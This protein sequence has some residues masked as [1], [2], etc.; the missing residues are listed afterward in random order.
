MLAEHLE[1][2]A[3]WPR[4]LEAARNLFHF[5]ELE[6]H[7]IGEDFKTTAGDRVFLDEVPAKLPGRDPLLGGPVQ[8]SGT[9]VKTVIAAAVSMAAANSLCFDRTAMT[10]RA[11]AKPSKPPRE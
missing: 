4:G 6:H 7:R 11:M 2:Y 10:A 9:K 8:F 3:V 5:V 1:I